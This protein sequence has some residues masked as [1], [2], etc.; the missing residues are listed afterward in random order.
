MPVGFPEVR[1]KRTINVLQDNTHCWTKPV[2]LADYVPLFL[3]MALFGFCW[4][5]RKVFM[6]EHN[7]YKLFLIP[8]WIDLSKLLGNREHIILRKLQ[9]LQ[10][11]STC[12]LG[13][14]HWARTQISL[15]LKVNLAVVFLLSSVCGLVTAVQGKW[16]LTCCEKA[17]WPWLLPS[18]HYHCLTRKWSH[19][20][21]S[22]PWD[23]SI[24][25]HYTPG[26]RSAGG[27]KPRLTGTEHTLV[28]STRFHD[29]EASVIRTFPGW[30][31]LGY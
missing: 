17:A 31:K 7:I 15:W 24:L 5:F 14:T 2:Y 21:Q 11:N 20:E 26:D 3:S 9:K 16:L 10:G 22:K 8:G 4:S 28:G 23:S 30:S 6:C 18:P 19:N 12:T 29:L 13:D 25:S 1:S 27:R